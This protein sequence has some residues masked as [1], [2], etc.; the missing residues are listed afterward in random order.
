MR[1]P[2][3]RVLPSV[4]LALVIPA[5][6][7]AQPPAPN[8]QAVYKQHCA[9]CHDGAMPRMPGRDALA[10]F[11]PEHIDN[12]LSSFAMRRQ[13]ATLRSA[14]RRA[15]A[16]FLSGRPP[17]SYRAPLDQIAKTAYCTAAVASQPNPLSGSAWNGWGADARNTRHQT[18]AAAGLSG[19][20]VPRLRVKWAFGL[21]GASASGSQVSVVGSRLFV[22]S[23][24]GIIY[25]LD[26]KTGC[27][28]WT[29][30]A[31]AG[32]RSTPV[33]NA[34]GTPTVF[35]GDAHAQA[36][37]LDALTGALKWK[38]K[39]DEHLDAMI[40]SGLAYANGRLYVPVSSLEE[41]SA[42]V[43]AYECC[44][45]RGSVS[46]LDAST[47]RQVW[48]TYTIPT[49]PSR[50]TRNSAGT[51]LWGPSGGGVWST[52]VIDAERNRLYIATGDSY[53]QPAAK[54]S[55]AV[56][57]L[58]IDTGRVLWVRQT[59]AG[60]AWTVACFEEKGPGRANCPDKAGPDYD[61]G[62][63]TALT[64]LPDGRRVLVAGQKS[65]T[66]YGI[67]PDSGD[68]LWTSQAGEGGV[69]GGIEWGFAIDGR[70]AYVSL[71]NALEKPPGQAG[72]LVAIDLADGRRRWSRPP[73]PNPCGG[74]TGCHTGQPAAVSAIPG[75][76]F[77]GSL[78]GHLRGYD[79]ESGQVIW[80]TDTG[81]GFETIN[82][83]TAN[84]GSFN[85]PGAVVAGGMLFVT[86]GYG[87]LG[88]MPGN[89]LL[90]FSLDGK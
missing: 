38:T 2:L 49:P 89:A 71:S 23:R 82:G 90:A 37:A 85:G 60:D 86:S 67:N 53:S 46:A 57:A 19:N 79:A 74:R 42:V 3:Q 6:A 18:S 21:P 63:A 73:A 50:T 45:F 8:G 72:G 75:V 48:K 33:V 20:D 24:N 29:F 61:F 28:V 47:G 87:T 26:A 34:T 64:T 44:T 27:I 76:V 14:E 78:D 56:M 80:D 1:T 66:L 81:R 41:G 62:S 70:V 15:V 31:D 52:P 25:S 35:F 55:D 54:E 69:L 88:F 17:G 58:A 43:A 4:A 32:V 9:A 84:G 40:T 51:Q 83:V 16:E 65:G 22:G 39:V 30:E 7:A 10:K 59:L 12:A 5:L 13:G 77:S 11:T 68:L 36:Y